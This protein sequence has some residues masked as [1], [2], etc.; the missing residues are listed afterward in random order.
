MYK[1]E[2]IH[3]VQTLK[4]VQKG[5]LSSQKR[6]QKTEQIRSKRPK[7]SQKTEQIRSLPNEGETLE[8]KSDRKRSKSVQF[9]NP[10]G[11]KR[12]KNGANPFTFVLLTLPPYQN[13]AL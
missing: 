13:A 3:P 7:P 10:I 4:T 5:A 6:V 11:W 1:T 9:C 12:A 2:H 8:G